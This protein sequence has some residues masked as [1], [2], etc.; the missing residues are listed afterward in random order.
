MALPFDRKSGS[1]REARQT[2]LSALPAA[3]TSPEKKFLGYAEKGGDRLNTPD[4]ELQTPDQAS[5]F[6]DFFNFRL[7]YGN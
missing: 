3:R 6:S 5:L 2:P 4:A 1:E 7:F